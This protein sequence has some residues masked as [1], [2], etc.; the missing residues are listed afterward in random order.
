MHSPYNSFH[1]LFFFFSSVSSHLLSITLL[2]VL[3]ALYFLLELLVLIKIVLIST[4]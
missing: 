4:F 1:M 3:G 2:V